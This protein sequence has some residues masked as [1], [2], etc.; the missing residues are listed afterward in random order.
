MAVRFV[1]MHGCHVVATSHQSTT[2]R[3][4]EKPCQVDSE[5]H[6][7]FENQVVIRVLQLPNTTR[8]VEW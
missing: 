3:A 4:V 7:R 1:L 6:D 2:I 8:L 5:P